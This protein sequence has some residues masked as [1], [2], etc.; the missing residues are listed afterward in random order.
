MTASQQAARVSQHEATVC[1]AKAGSAAYTAVEVA[2]IAAA[3][4]SIFF[5]F[6]SISGLIKGL[7]VST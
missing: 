5:I 2:T 4:R 3:R 1:A 7:I 6:C